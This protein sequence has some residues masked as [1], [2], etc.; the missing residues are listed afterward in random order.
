MFANKIEI[1]LLPSAK[2]VGGNESGSDRQPILVD[3]NS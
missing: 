2:V 3:T 1:T